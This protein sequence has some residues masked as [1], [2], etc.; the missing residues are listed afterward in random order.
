MGRKANLDLHIE[1]LI[2]HDLP[3][4]QRGRIAAAIEA[5]LARLLTER[6]VPESWCS[7]MPAID[8]GAVDVSPH[9]PAEALGRQ[10]AETVYAGFAGAARNL[11]PVRDRP[12]GNGAPVN[13]VSG[14]APV[15]HLSR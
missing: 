12:E 10:V 14:R 11:A 15:S 5:E 2:L 8:A 7:D 1:E 13:S 4:S 3:Y 6:G 9:L